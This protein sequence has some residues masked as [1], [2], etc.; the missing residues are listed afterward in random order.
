MNLV[1]GLT[2]IDGPI[3]RNRMQ[4]TVF[5]L[6]TSFDV[7]KYA[8]KWEVKGHA[9]NEA[10]QSTTIESIAAVADGWQIY[11]VLK[12]PRRALSAKEI[13]ALSLKEKDEYNSYIPEY[14]TVERTLGKMVVVLMFRPLV[15][16]KA[17]NQVY[18]NQSRSRV[19][20]EVDG[21]NRLSDDTGIL[22]NKDLNRF[23]I[24]ERDEESTGYL[25]T[26]PIARPT[27]ATTLVV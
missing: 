5:S 23:G 24:N 11:K 21:D 9:V 1:E 2:P 27:E 12:N 19:G 15:L 6:P 16:Q 10:M 3:K 18:A 8:A 20:E 25:K 7:N 13:Q 26:T 4:G 17:L 14:E 22:T